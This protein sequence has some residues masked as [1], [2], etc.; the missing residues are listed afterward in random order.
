MQHLISVISQARRASATGHEWWRLLP[1]LMLIR[2]ERRRGAVG[3]WLAT[4]LRRPRATIGDGVLDL[5]L[6]DGRKLF[7]PI[8]EQENVGQ[9]IRGSLCHFW[10]NIIV[11]DQYNATALVH[12]GTTVLD[13][14]AHVGSFA[15]LAA[16]LVGQ[17]GNV[18]SIEPVESN[19]RCLRKTVE[20]N[21][22]TSVTPV[23]LAV[24]ERDG[25]IRISL[26]HRSWQHSAVMRHGDAVATVPMRSVDS[27]VADLGLQRVDFIK[28]DIEGMEPELLRGAAA[29]IRR[30]RPYLAV[31]A[32]H[33]PQHRHTLPR[34]LREIEP[35]YHIEV[36][37]MARG[38]E[39]ELFAYP[40]GR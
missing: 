33:S 13:V 37:S 24:G 18:I 32:Y 2:P 17:H 26:S 20:A 29:T 10:R 5:S 16:G 11:L 28:G 39:T 3:F 15:L 35:S 9:A 31:S 25:E 34:V 14:G 36:K 12:S 8:S 23:Q 38:L 7:V 40:A 6:P 4:I 27:I 21:N 30:F 19:F 1:D 22:L